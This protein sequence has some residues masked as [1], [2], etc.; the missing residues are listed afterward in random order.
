MAASMRAYAVN[1]GALC[2]LK[3]QLNFTA[4]IMQQ[5][6][7]N[8]GVLLEQK[9]FNMKMEEYYWGEGESITAQ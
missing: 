4:Y 2:I 6:A 3:I 8:K 9:R 5:K 7:I 1:L